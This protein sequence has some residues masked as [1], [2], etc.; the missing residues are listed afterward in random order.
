MVRDKTS[1][2]SVVHI[3]Y[4]FTYTQRRGTIGPAVAT[5]PY[6]IKLCSPA[7]CSVTN[8]DRSTCLIE[9]TKMLGQSIYFNA[10]LCDYYSKNAESVQFQMKCINCGTKYHLP[11]NEILVHTE[12][13]T[14]FNVHSTNAAHDNRS[15]KYHT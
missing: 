12:T 6:E 9:G 2:D 3:P 13:T 11:H 8:N 5:S 14:N 4:K 10:T 15:C 1:N 7:D